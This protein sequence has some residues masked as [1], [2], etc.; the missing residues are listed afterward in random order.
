M[1]SHIHHI[2]LISML[3][4]MEQRRIQHALILSMALIVKIEEPVPFSARWYSHKFNAAGVRYEIGLRLINP[5]ITWVCGPY[6]CGDWPDL[7]IARAVYTQMI[8]P[9]EMTLAD[10]TYR[11]V[12]YFIHPHGNPESVQKQ[13]QFMARHETV[14][15]RMKSF[16]VLSS[17]YR[18]NLTFHSNCFYAVANIVQLM[19]MNGEPL[20]D[21]MP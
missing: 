20:Y 21:V 19:I 11:D 7:R 15:G 4:L 17:V 3:A 9:G 8:E 12:L 1:T 14:N 5:I 6:P 16:R 18:H 2:R 13:K 10:D